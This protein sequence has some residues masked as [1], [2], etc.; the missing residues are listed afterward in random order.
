MACD[1]P[2][3]REEKKCRIIELYARD[4]DA[5][6]R[7]LLS[8]EKLVQKLQN[9]LAC[10]HQLHGDG[11]ASS[12][13]RASSSSSLGRASSS[14]LLSSIAGVSS[15]VPSARSSVVSK[16]DVAVERVVSFREPEPEPHD[17]CERWRVV[18]GCHQKKI[19]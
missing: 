12:L 5:A 19:R 16:Q 18:V 14:S 8:S 7:L 11:Q 13:G 2:L 3:S 17:P 1:W 4:L 6:D 10:T 15:L 9:E